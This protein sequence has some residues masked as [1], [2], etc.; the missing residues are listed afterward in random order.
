MLCP[1][2]ARQNLTFVY[3][4]ARRV[5]RFSGGAKPDFRSV[6]PLKIPVRW[7]RP[8]FR[9]QPQEMARI[10]LSIG[11]QVSQNAGHSLIDA[12]LGARVESLSSGS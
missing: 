3:S 8:D 9:R 4:I 7:N 10:L 1:Y 11:G 2:I 6:R 5:V 12:T